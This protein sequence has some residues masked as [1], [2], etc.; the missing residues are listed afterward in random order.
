MEDAREN[1][2]RLEKVR[3]KKRAYFLQKIAEDTEK[4]QQYQVEKEKAFLEKKKLIT[5]LEQEKAQVLKDFEKRKKNLIHHNNKTSITDLSCEVKGGDSLQQNT[6]K[7]IQASQSQKRLPMLGD[8]RVGARSA[9]N[10]NGKIGETSA[11]QEP[12]SSI[13]LGRASLGELRRPNQ[14]MNFEKPRSDSLGPK[15]LQTSPYIRTHKG[16]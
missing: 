13:N 12:N 2:E 14:S 4:L 5:Q 11:P 7:N 1:N 10:I 15:N 6:S 16:K 9:K 3:E 8:V